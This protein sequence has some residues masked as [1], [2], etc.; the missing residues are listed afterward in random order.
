MTEISEI[1]VKWDRAVVLVKMRK[2][3][4]SYAYI[5]AVLGMSKEETYLL[6]LWVDRRERNAK[7]I[8]AQYNRVFSYD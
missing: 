1:D 7:K 2:I 8:A 4:R 5:G 6:K 3:N